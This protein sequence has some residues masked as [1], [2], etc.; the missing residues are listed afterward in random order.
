MGPLRGL[1]II[2]MAGLGPAPFVG[3]ML[4]DMGADV[5][6][7]D[8]KTRAGGDAFDAVREP[9][10]VDRGRRSAALDLKTAEGVAAAS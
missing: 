9:N 6:R 1:K 2:E 5:I 7:I 10:F 4:S 3:M 8:R